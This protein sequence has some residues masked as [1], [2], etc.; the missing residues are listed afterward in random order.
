MAP[1]YLLYDCS[2]SRPL[3]SH[4]PLPCGRGNQTWETQLTCWELTVHAEGWVTGGPRVTLPVSPRSGGLQDKHAWG[5]GWPYSRVQGV[6]CGGA[7]RGQCWMKRPG[8]L[9]SAL[10]LS[11]SSFSAFCGVWGVG[12]PVPAPATILLS[13]SFTFTLI[14]QGSAHTLGKKRVVIFFKFNFGASM[15]GPEVRTLCFHCQGPKF[16]SWPGN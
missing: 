16:S 9:T 4:H 10:W 7:W 14:P 11:P 6:G 13:S 15:V 1:F 2:V 3:G 8:A 12:T 5:A